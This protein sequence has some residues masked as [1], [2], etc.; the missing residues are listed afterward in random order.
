MSTRRFIRSDGKLCLEGY[1]IRIILP[2]PNDRP[3]GLE[4]DGRETHAY[5]TL[6][7]AKRDA[8]RQAD[9]ID[10]FVGNE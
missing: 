7:V 2:G 6:A 4:H 1:P 3:Y 10:E 8:E 9:E 5:E